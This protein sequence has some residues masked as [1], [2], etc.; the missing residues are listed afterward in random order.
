MAVSTAAVSTNS[1]FPVFRVC[2]ASRRARGFERNPTFL[3]RSR[4]PGSRR[5]A[6]THLTAVEFAKTADANRC[7]NRLQVDERIV[8]DKIIRA[9]H[10]HPQKGDFGLRILIG[11]THTGMTRK[12]NQDR[13]DFAQLSE[14]LA[15]AVLCDGMGGEN[16]GHIASRIACDHAREALRRDLSGDMGETTLRGVMVSAVTSAN[17]LVYEAAGKDPSLEGM[18]T[19]MIVAVFSA[20]T[21]YVASVGDSRVYCVSPEREL[22]VSRDHT[23]VQMLV[24]IGEIT[25]EDAINHPKRHFITRAVGVAETIDVDFAVQP[26]AGDD[27]V[28]LCSDGLYN[29]LTPGG[30]YPLLEQCLRENS[31]DCLIALANAGGG[32]DN[33]TAIVAK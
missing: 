11:G 24:D 18:G 6:A 10:P 32:T 2:F 22:Q 16:G 31:A 33:I 3:V 17:A 5:T 9:V 29:Y 30:F 27:I 21:L 25:E 15:F 7:E 4:R 23:V 8:T 19:T 28:L 20:D 14:T 1:H 26:L 12:I 13:Y